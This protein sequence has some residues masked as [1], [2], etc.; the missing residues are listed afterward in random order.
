MFDI[1]R[2]ISV[3]NFFLHFYNFSHSFIILSHPHLMRRYLLKEFGV[4]T[5]FGLVFIKTTMLSFVRLFQSFMYTDLN[6]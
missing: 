2:G 1:L 6:L 5:V 4:F 3:Q